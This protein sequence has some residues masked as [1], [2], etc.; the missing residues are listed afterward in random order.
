MPNEWGGKSY[1]VSL[2]D[3][4]TRTSEGDIGQEGGGTHD[5]SNCV[6]IAAQIADDA[7]ALTEK[8]K[9]RRML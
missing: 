1:W 9:E 2:C 3:P 8:R 4:T 6:R 7:A 5:C